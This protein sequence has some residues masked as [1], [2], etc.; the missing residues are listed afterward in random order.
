MGRDIHLYPEYRRISPDGV[1]P[2]Y[3][4]SGKFNSPRNYDLFAALGASVRSSISPLRGCPKDVAWITK[5]DA[6]LFVENVNTDKDGYCS[7]EN[8]TKWVKQGISKWNDNGTA[9]THPDWHSHT[10]LTFTEWKKAINKVKDL[11]HEYKALTQA[12]KY[13]VKNGYE[14]RFVMWF[15]N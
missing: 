14:V 3:N 7:L 2:W 1:N 6:Y 4:F 10:W 5:Y 11:E 13:L 15:D 9:V 12:M 8:A